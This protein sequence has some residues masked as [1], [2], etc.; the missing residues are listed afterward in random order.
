MT[1]RT[2]TGPR[3]D[4]RVLAAKCVEC[5]NG[6]ELAAACDLADCPLYPLRPGQPTPGGLDLVAVLTARCLQCC[7]GDGEAV[8]ACDADDCPLWPHRPIEG[9]AP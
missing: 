7:G 6:I 3:L 5:S 2:D 9:G 1:T 4:I 8:G